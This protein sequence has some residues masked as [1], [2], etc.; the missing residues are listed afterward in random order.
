MGELL[1][2]GA[3]D[4]ARLRLG[5]KN[6]ADGVPIPPTTTWQLSFTDGK[7]SLEASSTDKSP[8]TGL[9]ASE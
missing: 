3:S 5:G 9:T 1:S 4:C 2:G 8:R 7:V 6:E